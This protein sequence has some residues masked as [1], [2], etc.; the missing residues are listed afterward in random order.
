MKKLVSVR[1]DSYLSYKIKEIEL[2]LSEGNVSCNE[3]FYRVKIVV[4]SNNHFSLQGIKFESFGCD[5]D[6]ILEELDDKDKLKKRLVDF[7]KRCLQFADEKAFKNH[8]FV[9]WY[10]KSLS[11][12]VNVAKE[13]TLAERGM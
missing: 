4:S 6:F 9:C 10:L 7:A 8:D 5:L 11:S 12:M 1:Y 2:C 3:S 13:R